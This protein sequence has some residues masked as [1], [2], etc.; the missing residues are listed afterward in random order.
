[1]LL[2]ILGILQGS[3]DNFDI[4]SHWNSGRKYIEQFQQVC[5]GVDLNFIEDYDPT[6][7][8]LLL[9]TGYFSL[10][11]HDEAI[12]IIKQLPTTITDLVDELASMCRIIYL[13]SLT[14]LERVVEHGVTLELPYALSECGEANEKIHVKPERIQPSS[15]IVIIRHGYDC[16]KMR[17]WNVHDV[18]ILD[19]LKKW[20]SRLTVVDL[21][22]EKQ[23]D[24]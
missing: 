17:G 13:L 12:K 2:W 7:T 1:M 23:E 4:R 22:M 11:F 24:S 19:E 5:A 16:Y 6:I 20:M 10:G 21:H 3:C 8:N 15:S 14:N 18:T 9:V